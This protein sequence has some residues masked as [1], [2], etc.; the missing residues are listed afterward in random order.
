MDSF[1]TNGDA[2]TSDNVIHLTDAATSLTGR[3]YYSYPVWGAFKI[4]CDMLQGGGNSA[5]GMCMKYGAYDGGL[6]ERIAAMAYQF[7]LIPIPTA[8]IMAW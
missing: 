2:Y 8:A 6:A 1:T 7:V 5:D 3:A 4:E